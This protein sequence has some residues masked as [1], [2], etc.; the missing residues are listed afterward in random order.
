MTKDY[1]FKQLR[2]EYQRRKEELL[3]HFV[4]PSKVYPY[5]R[6][7]GNV[8]KPESL[9]PGYPA[10]TLDQRNISFPRGRCLA[11]AYS[12]SIR[13]E[14]ALIAKIRIRTRNSVVPFDTASVF[15]YS[16]F[17]GWVLFYRHDGALEYY[18]IECRAD[19]S[20]ILCEHV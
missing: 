6:L 5:Y 18:S 14:R 15:V 12:N 3:Y 13:N 16:D 2:E 9:S 10:L 7:T 8:F 11:S 17:T 19:A 20:V 4:L 1:L